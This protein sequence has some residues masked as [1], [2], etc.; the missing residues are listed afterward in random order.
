VSSERTTPLDPF[1]EPLLADAAHLGPDWLRALRSRGADSA[2]RLGVPGTSDEE[3]RTI[4]LR[5]LVGK[6]WAP[7]TAVNTAIDL[8]AFDRFV[9]PEA[10]GSRVVFVDGVLSPELTNTSAL[11]AGV[12]Q[13][14]S[15][16]I[17]G[18]EALVR[19]HIGRM[20]LDAD[21]FSALNTARMAEGVVVHLPKGQEQAAPIVILFLS[22]GRSGVAT[23]PRALIVAEA[24]SQATVIEEYVGLEGESFTNAVT[25]VV[26]EPNARLH[27]VK[28]QS[29]S[30]QAF[31]VGTTAV[32][33]A[34]DGH[35][36]STAI[37]LGAALSRH[38]VE[39]V[40]TGSN[41]HSALDGLVIL[42]GEQVADTHTSTDHRQPNGTSAQVHKVIASERSYG[43]FNGKIVV[44]QDAQKISANQLSR[45][46]LLSDKA[47][48]H[49][50]PQLEIFADDV[51]CT[52]GATIGQLE[53]EQV[54][55]LQSR[56]LDE[57][58]ARALLTY[59][60]AAQIVETL[61][62]AS[63]RQRLTRHIADLFE[64]NV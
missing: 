12:V 41:A 47:R 33:V 10:S 1:L 42:D 20:A 19:E 7:A 44:R 15:D 5:P 28:I 43:V 54:F 38:T 8:Q 34:R 14:L 36:V 45:S 32:R 37:T 11:G 6:A 2:R 51:K 4:R 31:H 25:E 35:L 13:S 18:D 39:V 57:A 40:Q 29:E 21:A 64:V 55:Y 58:S 9:L 23:F 50:K 46:L 61:P 3:W 60:F 27:L 16:A 30:K 22:T 53:A 24:G 26:V 17:D 62:V 52:H 56:G 63:I 49:T 59:A 48:V